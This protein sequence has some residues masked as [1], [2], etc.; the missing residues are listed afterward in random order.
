M[1]KQFKELGQCTIFTYH[2]YITHLYNV[3]MSYL[4][5]ESYV[6]NFNEITDAYLMNKYQNHCFDRH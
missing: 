1:R 4:R 6:F 5:L 2:S 3:N